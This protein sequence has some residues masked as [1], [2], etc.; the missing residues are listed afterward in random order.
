[1]D[2]YALVADVGGTNA[3][4][5]LYHLESGALDNVTNF[6]VAAFPSLEQV[7][8]KYLADTKTSLGSASI[9]IACPV[10]GDWVEMTNHSWKFSQQAM[11]QSLGLEN[12]EV[13]NDFAAIAMSI[14]VLPESDLTR[15]GGEAPQAGQPVAIFG[16]GTGMGVAH[17][18]K[19]DGKWICLPGEG[20]HVDFAPGSPEELEILQV[21]SRTHRHVSVERLLTGSGLV[22]IYKALGVL[23]RKPTL[24]LSPADVT[25]MALED[26]NELCLKTLDLFCTMLGRFG[27]NLALTLGCRGGVYIAGGIVPRFEK[28]LLRSKFRE[29]FEDKGRL[30]DFVRPVPVYL[31]KHSNPG[32][33]GAGAHLRQKLGMTL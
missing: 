13:L 19:I 18:I 20:G 21:I 30:A 8:V 7:I 1:M 2:K 3:R 32:L 16:P 5:A 28:F 22:R 11:Q 25:R 4:L 33:L 23:Q 15:I 27:G 12:L 6:A 24:D 26:N 14:P 31:V 29:A 9:A 17:L 10:T